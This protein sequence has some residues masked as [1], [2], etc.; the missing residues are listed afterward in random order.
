[1]KLIPTE[2]T[3]SAMTRVATLIPVVPRK[4]LIGLAAQSVRPTRKVTRSDA[5]IS[6]PLSSGC[7]KSFESVIM[8][9]ISAGPTNNGKANGVIAMPCKSVSASRRS[10]F[11][12]RLHETAV[13]GLEHLK[14]NDQCQQSAC[15]PEVVQPHVEE[16]QNLPPQHRRDDKQA[17]DRSGGQRND[18]VRTDIRG[19]V[20]QTHV[21][22]DD[23][24]GVD[25]SIQ[26]HRDAYELIPAHKSN[27]ELQC[28]ESGS[29]GWV[30]PVQDRPGR[31][32]VRAELSPGAVSLGR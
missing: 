26:Q 28:S 23:A 13:V 18:A 3:M 11:L 31:A 20:D 8:T 21:D 10:S 14:R 22:R 24:D 4:R 29:E 9:L 19:L 12:E 25:E 32:F 2:A 5:P 6:P 7:G 1:M 27:L 16:G 30:G 17:R 15:N